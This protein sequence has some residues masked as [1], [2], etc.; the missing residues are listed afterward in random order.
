MTKRMVALPALFF[1]L[2]LGI[3]VLSQYI[4]N[5]SLFNFLPY[6]N[7]DYKINEDNYR[8]F[9]VCKLGDIG[10]IGSIQRKERQ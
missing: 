3:K 7:K 2:N 10:D 5:C 9:R 1:D 8:Y 6:E 4:L